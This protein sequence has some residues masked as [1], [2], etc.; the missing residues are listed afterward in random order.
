MIDA[1]VMLGISREEMARRLALPIWPPLTAQ[2]A[3]RPCELYAHS[4]A[5]VPSR[6]QGHHRHAVYLQNRVYGEIRDPE[7]MWLCG[8][9]HDSVHDVVSWLLR[10]ARRPNPMPGRKAVRE[11]ER[12]VDWYV[13]ALQDQRPMHIHLNAS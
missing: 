9:C 12:T 10:E 3:M 7:L 13:A 2:G 6:T 11:A 5:P 4:V 8:L 1:A